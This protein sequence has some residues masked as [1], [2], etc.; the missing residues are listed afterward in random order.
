LENQWEPEYF[1]D[2]KQLTAVIVKR[3]DSRTDW[4]R[5]ADSSAEFENW[6]KGE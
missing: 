5:S 1:E 6:L 3:I 4:Y 2:A